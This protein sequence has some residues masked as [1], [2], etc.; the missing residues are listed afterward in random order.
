MTHCRLSSATRDAQPAL[1]AACRPRDASVVNSC[2]VPPQ[3]VSFAMSVF[4]VT[5]L[6][7]ASACL[8]CIGSLGFHLKAR[9]TGPVLHMDS[10]D[11]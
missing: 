11:P 8:H 10:T 6:D 3:K 2:T 1:V 4:R 9:V 7:K 5:H